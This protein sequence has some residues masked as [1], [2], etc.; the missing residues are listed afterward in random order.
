MKYMIQ[1]C[2]VE[3][4]AL[5]NERLDRP[6]YQTYNL[7]PPHNQHIPLRGFANIEV[8]NPLYSLSYRTP[9]LTQ[10]RHQFAVDVFLLPLVVAPLAIDK[11]PP[12]AQGQADQPQG[13]LRAVAHAIGI[14]HVI[15]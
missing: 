14:K 6:I 12:L 3:L 10:N 7:A 2:F 13:D 11:F 9:I 8:F 1:H 15:P 5:I 4:Q